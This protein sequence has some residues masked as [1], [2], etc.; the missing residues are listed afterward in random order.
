MHEP[1]DYLHR[2]PAEV[3]IA[4][5]SLCSPRQLR[6]IS[7]VCNLFR[8]LSLPFLFQ[9]QTLDL[10][11][12]MQGATPDNWVDHFH[13][14][15]RMAVRLDAL[16][17]SPFAVY[18][19][20]WR[21]CLPSL[22]F[23]SWLRWS[24][25]LKHLGLFDAMHDRATNIFFA[26]LGL[27]RTISSLHI[28]ID[29]VDAALWETL[30]CIPLLE[31]LE[32]RASRFGVGDQS[33]SDPQR[34]DTEFPA[35]SWMLRSLHL[36]DGRQLLKAFSANELPHLVHL[37][38]QYV[39]VMAPFVRFVAQCP[40]LESIAVHYPR[41]LL[42]GFSDVPPYSLPLLHTLVG[43]SCLV[44]SLVP[45]RS[46][47]AVSVVGEI[48]LQ[49]LLS[50]CTDI[51]RSTVPVHH[52][53]LPR[54]TPT[55]EFLRSVVALLPHMRDLWLA[56]PDPRPTR[57]GFLCRHGFH[58]PL[59]ECAVDERVPAFC[60]AEAFDGLPPEEIS[61][62]EAE[63]V[64]IN[65]GD[66]VSEKS[67]TPRARHHIE[68]IITWIREGLLDLPPNIESF[69]LRPDLPPGLPLT[70]QHRALVTLSARYP[71][72]REVQVGGCGTTWRRE[73]YKSYESRRCI[74]AA[75]DRRL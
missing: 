50:L 64:P 70:Q 54:A 27:Y 58:S 57:S 41:S 33:V 8:S 22:Q 35:A 55:I 24:S 28:T 65:V 48:V 40:R 19:R 38:I 34:N 59:P 74:V 9:H 29:V 71:S 63:D 1:V 32:L 60:D 30:R 51:S 61:D 62:E 25:N 49:D 46:M 16:A 23:R 69:R 42:P 26:T 52:L 47:R 20:S 39:D 36:A 75:E 5:W 14:L 10:T 73:D 3:W 31:A 17:A 18:V 43:P 7:V 67:R 11:A 6:R 37:S 4:C 44:R 21:V 72:L 68:N 45:N 66:V 2:V 15:H 56:I 13:R 12:V 53:A